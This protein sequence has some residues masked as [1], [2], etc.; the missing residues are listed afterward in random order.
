M[1]KTTLKKKDMPATNEYMAFLNAIKTDIVKSQLHAAI[2]ITQELVMLYWRIGHALSEKVKT[3]GWGTKTIETLA[4]D[5]KIA[6]PY[7]EGYSRSNLYR[8]IAFYEAY[9][10]CRAA[11]RQIEECPIFHIPWWHNVVILQKVKDPEQRLWYAQKAIENG[12]SRS[13]LGMWIESDYYN[14]KGKAITNFKERLSQPGSGLAQETLNDPYNLEFLTIDAKAHEHEIE[15]GLMAH[16]EKFLL[17]LGKGFAF[18]GRQYHFNIG[19]DDIYIDM[20]FYH[21]DL[22]CYIVVELKAKK[23]DMRDIGQINTY[24]AAVDDRMRRPGDNPSIGLL[25]CKEKNNYMAEYALRYA[26]APIG[27]ASYTTAIVES[28]PKE[29]KGSLPTIKEIEAELEKSKATVEEGGK[30][31]PQIDTKKKPRKSQKRVKK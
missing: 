17:E 25:L 3:E 28:L 9:Q 5:I 18:M 16:M 6:F 23:F 15:K 2:L 21:V 27:V 22:R 19:G 10:N 31:R 29:L 13:V 14:R 4:R 12:W 24:L 20:L 26:S 1:K 30:E 7:L 11:A 8:M